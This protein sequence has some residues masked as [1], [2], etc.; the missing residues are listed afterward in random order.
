MP[1]FDTSLDNEKSWDLANYVVSLSPATKPELKFVV[2]ARRISGEVPEDP[3]DPRWDG[4]E[5]FEFPMVGQVIQDAPRN[6]IA[7]L[8]DMDVKAVYNDKEIAIKLVWDDPTRSVPI[9]EKESFADAVAIQ[10]PSRIPAGATKPYFLNGDSEN[11][12]NLW[13]WK[14]DTQ[15]LTG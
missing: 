15:R 2:K 1:S 3:E 11:P 13:K 8:N 10:F 4:M 14:S 7:M 6:F 5:L 9:A 12:V